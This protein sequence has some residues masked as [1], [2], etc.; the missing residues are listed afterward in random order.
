MKLIVAVFALFAVASAFPI[1]EDGWVDVDW[2]NTLPRTE[3][4]GFWDGRDIRPA[5]YPG[6]PRGRIVGGTVAAPNAHPYQ[7]ALHIN[8]NAGQFLCGGSIISGTVVLSA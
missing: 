4:P 2:S 6:A 8:T 3:E 1:E 5:F 7:A